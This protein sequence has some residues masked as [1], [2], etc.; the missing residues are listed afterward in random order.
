[1]MVAM[2]FWM[3]Y[4]Y[5]PSWKS[6]AIAWSALLLSAVAMAWSQARD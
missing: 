5:R 1:M 6:K 4:R 2:S 3:A